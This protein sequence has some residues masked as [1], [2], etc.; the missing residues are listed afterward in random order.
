[1]DVMGVTSEV[2]LC[3][4][5]Y[6]EHTRSQAVAKIADRPYCLT[7]DQ[8]AEPDSQIA[9]RSQMPLTKFEVC[10]SSSFEDMFNSMPNIVGSRD[11]GHRP[12]LRKIICAPARHSPYKAMHQI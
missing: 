10:S 5:R 4:Y 7:V 11:L 9:M 3:P 6:L 12:L 2:L 8:Y 1:M